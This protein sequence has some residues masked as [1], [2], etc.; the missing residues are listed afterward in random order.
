MA[1][2][3]TSKEEGDLISAADINSDF[4]D[5]ATTA[6]LLDGTEIEPHTLHSEHL[7]SPVIAS[8]YASIPHDFPPS[9]LP[10]YAEHT[11]VFFEQISYGGNVL[12][13]EFPA[14]VV[15]ADVRGILVLANVQ[16]KHIFH[17]SGDVHWKYYGR[18]GL[19]AYGSKPFFTGPETIDSTVRYVDSETSDDGRTAGE[20]SATG[21][22]IDQRPVFKDVAIRAFITADRVDLTSIDNIRLVAAT[23]NGSSS[24]GS[25]RVHTQA[26]SI[27]AIVLRA[28]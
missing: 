24:G 26:G 7:P 10:D 8:A 13:A 6:N 3:Y 27:T 1:I 15:M 22:D 4:T 19:Q 12:R 9:P 2:S 17:S 21:L 5:I 20:T 14:S 28:G 23:F 25:A 11:S 16:V 18:F